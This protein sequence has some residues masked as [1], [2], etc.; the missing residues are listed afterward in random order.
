MADSIHIREL[1]LLSHIGVPD[2][3]RR[4][5]QR[6]TLNLSIEPLIPFSALQDSIENTVDYDALAKRI[7]AIARNCPRHLIETLVEDIAQTILA[8][9]PVRSVELEL[10]KF[11]LPDTAYVAV[12]V[13]RTR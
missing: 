11:I 10:R 5:P 2:L 8:E 13:F 6:L 7:Q 9:F 12:R 1:E 4:F 3:E